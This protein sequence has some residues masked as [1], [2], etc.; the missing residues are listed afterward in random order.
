MCRNSLPIL[1]ILVSLPLWPA[2]AQVRVDMNHVTCRQFLSYEPESKNF[3]VYWMSGYYNASKNND[4]LN[5]RRLQEN[6][7][8]I[9]TYCKKHTADPLPKAINKVAIYK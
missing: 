5:F 1:A 7:E 6:A 9:L 3:V 4:V 2:H 8:K